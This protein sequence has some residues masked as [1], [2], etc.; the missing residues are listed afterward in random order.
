M[1]SFGKA[2]PKGS[3]VMGRHIATATS[4]AHLPS[5]SPGDAERPRLFWH[6]CLVE[7][8]GRR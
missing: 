3:P 5:A 1:I 2:V 4:G 7:K 8:E 6:R